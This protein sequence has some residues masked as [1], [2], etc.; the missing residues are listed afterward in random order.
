MIFGAAITGTLK[1]IAAIL[2][3]LVC[4]CVCVVFWLAGKLD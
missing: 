1:G 3:M 4:V 2:S